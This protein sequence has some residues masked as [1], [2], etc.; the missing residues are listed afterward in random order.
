MNLLQKTTF[1]YVFFAI[2]DLGLCKIL[3]GTLKPEDINYRNF[4]SDELEIEVKL[5]DVSLADAP[6]TT[7]SSQIYHLNGKSQIFPFTFELSYKSSQ[8]KPHKRYSLSARVTD[9]KTKQLLFLTTTHYGLNAKKRIGNDESNKS[10]KKQIQVKLEFV[11]QPLKDTQI[12]SLKPEGGL[13]RAYFE[14]FFFNATSSKCE[15]FIYGGCGGNENRF[16]SE[17]ECLK[18]CT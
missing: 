9:S 10:S 2:F 6:A 18:A 17:A 15:K 16:S 3:K 13:C 8:I 1:I 7:I 5:L 12:C 11:G 4:N 14:R